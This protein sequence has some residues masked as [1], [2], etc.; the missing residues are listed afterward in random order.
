MGRRWNLQT[1]E[2]PFVIGVQDLF[3]GNP[4]TVQLGVE[5]LRAGLVVWQT[6]ETIPIVVPTGAIAGDLCGA[7]TIFGDLTNVI[8][9]KPGETL[10]LV[11]TVL[12]RI[13]SGIRARI[14]WSQQLPAGGSDPLASPTLP[15]VQR[16][17]IRY[18]D[19]P[20]SPL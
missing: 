12:N 1:I 19:S 20:D 3:A 4:T 16:G 5:L 17:V 9:I 14:W 10:R 2:L 18:V 13:G 11:F 8:D 7:T 6:A 15:V